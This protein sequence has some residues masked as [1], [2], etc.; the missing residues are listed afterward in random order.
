M[1]RDT[2]DRAIEALDLPALIADLYPSSG[3]RAGHPGGVKGVW[4]G[5][6]TASVSLS[7]IGGRWLWNDLATGQG[8][9]AY[10][11]FTEVLDYSPAQAADEL[12]RRAGLSDDAV[13]P[14]RAVSA[15]RGTPA[16][17]PAKV[18]A[19][20]SDQQLGAIQR[21]LE[22]I[23]ANS[24]AARDLERRGLPLTDYWQLK[25]SKGNAKASAVV[26]PIRNHEGAIMNYKVRNPDPL[27]D[28]PRYTY[29]ASGQ[30]ALPDQQVDNGGAVL[31]IEGE[32]NAARA[33]MALENIGLTFAVQG[34]AGVS[35][36][37]DLSRVAEREVFVYADGDAPGV[38]AARAWSHTALQAGATVAR[39]LR[40]LEGERDFCDLTHDALETWINEAI[41]S[42]VTVTL[43]DALTDDA[44][45][46]DEF[47]VLD[48]EAPAELDDAALYGLAG[49]VVRL[50]APQ[51]EAHPASLLFSFFVAVGIALGNGVAWKIGGVPH[52][53]RLFLVL[54]GVSGKGRKGTS[55]GV[56]RG[57][58]ETA[59]GADFYKD[60]V[61]TGLSS[62]EGLIAAV[63]DPVTKMVKGKGDTPEETT[64]D[65]GVKDK[66]LI[67]LESEFGRT[68]KVMQREGSTLSAVIRQAWEIG[69]NDALNV[70]TKVRTTATGAHVGIVGH[71]TRDELLRYLED[72]ETANGFANRFLWV[73]TRRV[74]ELP[75]GGN[76]DA[77]AMGRLGERLRDALQWVAQTDG[78][79]T[80]HTDTRPLWAAIYGELSEGSSGLT[81]AVTSRA[82]SYVMR[83][84]GLYA[85]LD[86]SLE[87]RPEHLQA[88]MAAWQYCADSV[89]GIFGRR[90]GDVIAD[91]ILEQLRISKRLT[92]TQ[93]SEIF[94]KNQSAG[95]IDRA[96]QLL[97]RDGKVRT[98]KGERKN[99]G[100]APQY[101]ELVAVQRG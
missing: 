50:I 24:S 11:F 99:G 34:V 80:W 62:G 33:R 70:L 60:H 68:L 43:E 101:L 10:Q 59:L 71:C 75:F 58:L 6:K 41:S 2:L 26:I 14:V 46:P 81:G 73:G 48:S 7:N 56:I 86:K 97:L 17:T 89:A 100:R 39:V 65:E 38:K 45:L 19:P 36:H 49:D 69:A 85:V 57:V 94:K 40:P 31:I 23:K 13:L 12:K 47:T 88:S 78:V 25:G 66:R 21:N 52:S 90:T 53:L 74:R 51:T 27:G 72:T 9:N 30:S 20:L 8:G 84:A 83:L 98:V 77:L 63:R 37:P 3:A 44:S 29:L 91:A 28:A 87:V 67:V 18:Y 61:T 22:P 16:P 4:R 42:A 15:A 32:L 1:S 93:V 64:I 79:L 95:A 5:D 96:V 54:I 92:R 55:W 76:P 82:E 35:N